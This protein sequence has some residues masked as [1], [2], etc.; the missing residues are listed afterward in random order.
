MSIH[1]TFHLTMHLHQPLPPSH[2]LSSVY[3][4]EGFLHIQNRVAQAIIDWKTANITTTPHVHVAMKQIPYPSYRIDAFLN[5]NAAILP[6]L[7]IMAFIYSAGMFTKVR[8]YWYTHTYICSF[9]S[10]LITINTMSFIVLRVNILSLLCIVYM[11]K[12]CTMC[13][14]FHVYIMVVFI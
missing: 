7:L 4:T 1:H 8:I 14:I 12:R 9:N 13:A 10:I 2:L 3:V 6:L 11:Y 5:W